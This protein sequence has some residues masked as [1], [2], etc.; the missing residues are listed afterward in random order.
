MYHPI[1]AAAAGRTAAGSRSGI[2]MAIF[3]AGGLIGFSIAPMIMVFIVEGIGTV[4]MPVVILPALLM[5]LYFAFTRPVD[6]H[7]SH[8]YSMKEWFAALRENSSDLIL[9]WLISGLR[10]IAYMMLSSFLPMLIMGR[11]ALYSESARWLT[12]SLLC[13]MLGL[14]V[15]GHLSD[16][17]GKRRT[18]A[19]SLFLASP[20]LY[21]FLF[22][23]GT[24]SLVFLC[25]GMASLSSTIPVNIIMAQQAAPKLAGTA[26]SLVMGLSVMLGAVAATPFGAFAD[27]IGIESAMVFPLALPAISGLFVFLLKTE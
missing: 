5:A 1:S 21:A 14:F 23:T 27:H 6:I 16:T 20:F 11:G 18:I 15:G 4:Y 19:L 7:E 13:S 17:F 25:L 22:T 10:A 2:L 24:V 8:G 26:S 12:I 3:S 9:L